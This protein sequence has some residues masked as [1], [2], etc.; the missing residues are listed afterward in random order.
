MTSPESVK[1]HADSEL[2]VRSLRCPMPLLK[3]RQS[4]RQLARGKVL[5]VRASDAG[6]WRDIPAYLGQSA[7]KLVQRQQL[8][9]EYCFWIEVGVQADA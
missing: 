8:D 1:L 3:T 4:L 7:H 9:N 6:S 5:L 2:D